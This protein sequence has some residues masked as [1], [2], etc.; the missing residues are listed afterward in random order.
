M[1]ISKLHKHEK[2]F[3][4]ID[5]SLINDDSISLEL[6]GLLISCLAKPDNWRFN[7]AHLS[8]SLKKGK[9][10]IATI[11]NE[12]IRAG[13]IKKVHH[14]NA[15][16]QFTEHDYIIS[17]VKKDAYKNVRIP[18]KNPEIKKISPQ[19]EN[20]HSGPKSFKENAKKSPSSPRQEVKK[21]LPLCNGPIVNGSPLISTNKN[22]ERIYVGAVQQPPKIREPDKPPIKEGKAILPM[23]TKHKRIPHFLAIRGLEVTDQ[24]ILANQFSERE[25]ALALEDARTYVRSG[26]TI[27]KLPAFIT[28]RCQH[29]RDYRGMPLKL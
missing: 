16:G 24:Q 6:K 13:Y 26:R 28:A 4:I 2:N 11:L 15:N 5:N 19:R 29:Y 20:F 14:R 18:S 8:K 17:E 3:T 7:I 25:L 22:K 10:A 1:S 21:I 9:Y 12:G 23:T 27:L